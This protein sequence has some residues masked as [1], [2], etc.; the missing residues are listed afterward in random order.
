MAALL[1]RAQPMVQPIKSQPLAQYMGTRPTTSDKGAKT[2]GPREAPRDV[3]VMLNTI[4]MLLVILSSETNSEAP[5]A[6]IVVAMFLHWTAVS[7][8]PC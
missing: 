3:M 5:G 7:M 1:L 2:K 6:Y 4:T 8:S